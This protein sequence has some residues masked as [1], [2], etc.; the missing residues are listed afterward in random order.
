MD[1]KGQTA[2]P[3][4][5][6]GG[7]GGEFEHSC[8]DGNISNSDPSCGSDTK[9]PNKFDTGAKF[10][11]CTDKKNPGPEASHPVLPTCARNL[12]PPRQRAVDNKIVCSTR[13]SDKQ[14][15]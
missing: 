7:G 11:H 2:Q 9:T 12:I 15:F 8:K 14:R 4:N 3:G 5:N 10:D 6:T 13:V 1:F